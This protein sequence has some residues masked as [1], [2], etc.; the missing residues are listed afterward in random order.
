VLYP[1]PPAFKFNTQQPEFPNC[2]RLV[3]MLP[4]ILGFFKNP[5]SHLTRKSTGNVGMKRKPLTRSSS[6]CKE[7]VLLTQT[8]SINDFHDLQLPTN[9]FDQAPFFFARHNSS[10]FPTRVFTYLL[11]DTRVLFLPAT[12]SPSKDD[13]FTVVFFLYFLESIVMMDSPT[14]HY[15]DGGTKTT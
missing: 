8:F 11:K 6:T 3:K 5:L 4:Y 9:L 13:F 1:P 7:M 10:H 14:D 2:L 15:T 12:C